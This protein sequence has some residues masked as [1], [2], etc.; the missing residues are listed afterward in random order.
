[1]DFL[2]FAVFHTGSRGF[3]CR[4]TTTIGT[5]IHITGM[6]T[7]ITELIVNAQPGS[8]INSY[9]QTYK[10]G[11]CPTPFCYSWRILLNTLA[12]TTIW[13]TMLQQFTVSLAGTAAISSRCTDI[14]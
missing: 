1:M 4:S 7:H 14:P 10:A 5:N 11:E 6:L 8:N 9:I 13:K 2:T 12:Q 3:S